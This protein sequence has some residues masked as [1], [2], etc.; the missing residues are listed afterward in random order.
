MD[1][2]QEY[3][4]KVDGYVVVI[5]GYLSI[6]MMDEFINLF[7]EHGYC[8]V[9]EGFDGSSLCLAKKEVAEQ[10]QKT[11]HDRHLESYFVSYAKNYAESKA[12][13]GLEK[14]N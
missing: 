7:S 3:S 4:I 1:M 8:Y 14:T 2:V 12:N 9:V 5:K 6:Q 11:S 10:M 13:G